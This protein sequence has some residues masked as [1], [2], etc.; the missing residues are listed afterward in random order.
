MDIQKTND[1]FQRLFNK[2]I[3]QIILQYTDNN[4][5]IQLQDYFPHSLKYITINEKELKLINRDNYQ[6]IRKLYCSESDI[7][8]ESIQCLTQ[9]LYLDCSGCQN[10]TDN[11]IIYLVRLT[12]L[13]CPFCP[14]ITDASIQ[15]LVRLTK[16]NYDNC[17]NISNNMKQIIRN[18]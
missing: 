3:I 12:Q 9:L 18:R 2:D 15:H 14:N 13:D 6:Y 17:P 10:I 4:V 8:D 1:V 5:I 7:T 16:L 11:G